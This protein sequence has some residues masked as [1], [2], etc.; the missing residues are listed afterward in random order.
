MCNNVLNS[1]PESGHDFKMPKSRHIDNKRE[2]LLNA[3]ERV[4]IRRG[5]AHLTLDAVAKEAKVGKGGLMYH[6][7]SKKALFQAMLDRAVDIYSQ[8]VQANL[9]DSSKRGNF[10]Q[11]YI[12]HL[13]SLGKRLEQLSTIIISI[14]ANDPE[15]LRPLQKRSAALYENAAK[16]KTG[17]RAVIAMLAVH[18]LFL[19][20]RLGV[21]P[22][23]KESRAQV[24]EALYKLVQEGA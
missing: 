6:F 4:A 12:R 14:A 3:A 7:P 23:G 9:G 17:N 22:L 5:A 24:I 10:A 19:M 1:P 2:V 15:L 11:A 18:G 21:G 20:E 8:S 13:T 16:D